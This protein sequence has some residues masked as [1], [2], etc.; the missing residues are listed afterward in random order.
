MKSLERY[1]R[2]LLQRHEITIVEFDL[3]RSKNIKPARAHRLPKVH[4]EFWNIPKFRPIIDTT[5]TNHC[6]SG[7]YLAGLLY[8]LTTNEFSLKDPF[9]AANR[10]KTVRSNLFKNHYQYL[11]FMY[12]SNEL[13]T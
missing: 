1:L 9:D 10:I 13:L 12:P 8:P 7:N 11:S 6:L 3:M 5:G 2:T 4:T